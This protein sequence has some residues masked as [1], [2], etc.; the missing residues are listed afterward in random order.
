MF[1]YDTVE[2]ENINI[3]GRSVKSLEVG[4]PV[5]IFEG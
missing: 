3:N 4:V 2:V 1:R 5:F